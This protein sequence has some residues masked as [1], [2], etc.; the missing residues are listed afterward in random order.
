[1]KHASLDTTFATQVFFEHCPQ[2]TATLLL[3]PTSQT[4]NP[5]FLPL[6]PFLLFL[7]TLSPGFLSPRNP[8]SSGVPS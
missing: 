5:S 4:L 6:L 8:L 3:F 7:P 1:M 2:G